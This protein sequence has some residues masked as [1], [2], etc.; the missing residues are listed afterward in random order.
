MLADEVAVERAALERAS[1]S[2]P[3]HSCGVGAGPDRQVQVGALAGGGAARVD[4]DDAHAALGSRRLDALI[5]HRMAPGRVG[6]D[7]HHEVGQ[8]QVV[9]ALRH[10]VGAEGAAMPG[11]R[12][13][14]AQP[15]V[16]VDMRRADEALGQLVGD[17]VVL[18]QQLPGEVEGD[19]FRPVRCD[20]TRAA[21]RDMVERLRPSRPAR[22]PISGCSSRAVQPQRLAERRA[23]GAQPA[24]I[25]R[26]LRIAGDRRAARAV[27]RRQHAAADAAIGAGGASGGGRFLQRPLP[28][29]W[30]RDRGGGD[31]R[32]IAVGLPPTPTLSPQ[33]GGESAMSMG[34]RAISRR[35]PDSG[36]RPS[37]RRRNPWRRPRSLPPCPTAISTSAV[38]TSLAM[39]LASPQ[40]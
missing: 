14:H 30:G 4:V 7:Q 35:P 31:R 13:G 27:R 10:D 5:Q 38:S 34:D 24:E 17:V 18:G 22:P 20:D 26:M 39:R 23:L 12:R 6:A 28:H 37:A 8:L 25:G 3:F 9:V 40:T 11:D 16:G 15:R 21:G 36:P 33:G 19:D 32:T 2:R 1:T 29:L